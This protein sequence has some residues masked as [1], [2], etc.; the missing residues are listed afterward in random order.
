MANNPFY[1]TEWCEFV[2][3]SHG[4]RF[5]A[6]DC[7]HAHSWAD[8]LGTDI[9]DW[10]WHNEDWAWDGYRWWWNWARHRGGVWSSSGGSSGGPDGADDMDARAQEAPP[11][12]RNPWRVTP[13]NRPADQEPPPPLPK[14]RTRTTTGGDVRELPEYIAPPCVGRQHNFAVILPADHVMLA[15][16][17]ETDVAPVVPPARVS[18]DA[19][20]R[21]S[22]DRV[23][24]K[25]WLDNLAA[26]EPYLEIRHRGN[27]IG[28]KRRSQSVPNRVLVFV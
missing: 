8:Y 18:T 11:P 10:P 22:A 3:R 2:V 9:P 28:S 6:A 5:S 23:D 12:H 16:T 17:I 20:A 15:C 13:A 1:K 14:N 26:K 21:G 25:S 4:C 27:K 24:H 19:D 7:K